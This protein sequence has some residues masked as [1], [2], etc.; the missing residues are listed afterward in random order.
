MF[1]KIEIVLVSLLL[2]MGNEMLGGF[3]AFITVIYYGSMLKVN[4]VDKH[5]NKS[6]CKYIKSFFLKR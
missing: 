3:V 4:V 1:Y 6:W 2:I 5:H